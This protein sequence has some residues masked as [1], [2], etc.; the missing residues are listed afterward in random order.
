LPPKKTNLKIMRG[1]SP[2]KQTHTPARKTTKKGGVSD[3]KEEATRT[4]RGV[5]SGIPLF[6]RGGTPGRKKIEKLET[7]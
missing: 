1:A 4:I 6:P 7:V 2:I 5:L 3:T